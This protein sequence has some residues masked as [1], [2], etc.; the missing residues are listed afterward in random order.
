[1]VLDLLLIF[2][3]DTL[4]PRLRDLF[5]DAPG[6]CWQGCGHVVLDVKP[7]RMPP[8]VGGQQTHQWVFVHLVVAE[9]NADTSHWHAQLLPLLSLLQEGDDKEIPP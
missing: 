3:R 6:E 1:M 4:V 7:K 8:L 5:D 2:D 9:M